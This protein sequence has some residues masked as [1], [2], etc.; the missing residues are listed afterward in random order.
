[1][2]TAGPM[3]IVCYTRYKPHCADLSILDS[4]VVVMVAEGAAA[5]SCPGQ[6]PRP[7]CGQ[8][9]LPTRAQRNAPSRAMPERPPSPEAVWC[10]GGN[11][12]PDGGDPGRLS[13]GLSAHACSSKHTPSLRPRAGPLRETYKGLKRARIRSR[14]LWT[15][16]YLAKAQGVDR[17]AAW[18]PDAR[19]IFLDS[20]GRAAVIGRGRLLPCRLLHQPQ[21]EETLQEGSAKPTAAT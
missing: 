17:P 4:G 10:A 18:L 21:R 11:D 13:H 7:H 5:T 1:V 15:K 6:S 12:P 9:G 14:F 19:G 20:K 8:M 16:I 3:H 2:G